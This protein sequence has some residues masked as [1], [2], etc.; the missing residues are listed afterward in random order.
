MHHEMLS[1]TM[2]YYGYNKTEDKFQNDSKGPECFY[3]KIMGL[4]NFDVK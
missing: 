1:T 3:S 4:D 2:K